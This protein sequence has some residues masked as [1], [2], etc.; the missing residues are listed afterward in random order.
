MKPLIGD[1]EE[2]C[3]STEDLLHRIEDCNQR[4][5][6]DN[7]IIASMDIEALYPSIDI[8]V[9]AEKC[10]DL[11]LESDIT[12]DQVDCEELGRLFKFICTD[13]DLQR[14]EQYCPSR[15]SNLGRKPKLTASGSHTDYESRCGRYGRNPKLYLMKTQYVR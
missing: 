15:I 3:D 7:C 12:F 13:V 9:A 8:D 6:L 5:N 11:L 1:A 2:V 4:K 10:S 14:F